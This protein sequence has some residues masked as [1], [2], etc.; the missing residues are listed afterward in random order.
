MF[1]VFSLS[2]QEAVT[3]KNPLF[4]SVFYTFF[5]SQILFITNYIT[6]IININNTNDLPK[7][8]C[9]AAASTSG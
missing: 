4:L 2:S 9:A 1:F 6:Q 3:K 8:Q 7:K 5:H